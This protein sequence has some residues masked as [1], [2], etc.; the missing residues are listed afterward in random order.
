MTGFARTEGTVPDGT[1]SWVW[2][3]RTV[4]GKGLDIRMRLPSGFESLEP[5]V[6]QAA[7]D[8]LTRGNLNV[9]LSVSY[10]T[11]AGGY[12]VNEDFLDQL[13]TLAAA[14]AADLPAN[15]GQASLDGLMAVRGVVEVA[16]PDPKTDE[17]RVERAQALLAGLTQAL[18]A[19]VQARAEEGQHMSSLLGA[20]LDEMESLTA[21]AKSSAA[22]QPDALKARLKANVEALL[23]G[24]T[25][26]PEDRLIQE[27]AVLATKADV[28]EELDRLVAH[29]AQGRDLLNKGEPCGRRLE[30]LSQEFNREANTLCSKSTDADLTKIGLDLKAVI[31]Q[32]R[33]QIQN[34]E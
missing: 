19:L 24:S 10:E 20:Q 11:A 22:T 5:K 28:R 16:D 15:V 32:F 33:E 13:I 17:E 31:D 1:V 30:F 21:A 34:V 29:I 23:E 7:A 4:N 2:E 14:K 8:H 25:A 12:C 27:A 26:L 3:L 9:A 6:R 18:E